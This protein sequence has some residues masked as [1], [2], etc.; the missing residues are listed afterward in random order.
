MAIKP[1]SIER[2]LQQRLPA[3]PPVKEMS[4]EQLH[5]I[6]YDFTGIRYEPVTA[7]RPQQL[8]GM[9]FLSVVGSG[10][11]FYGMRTGK[12]KMV[13]DWFVHRRKMG[14]ASKAIS[15]VPNPVIRPVW[16]DEAA[17]HQPSLRLRTIANDPMEFVDAA[18]DANVDMVVASW[19]SLQNI[20]AT[21]RYNPETKR[22]S[23]VEDLATIQLAAEF[24]DFAAID[25]IHGAK[26][27]ESLRYNICRHLIRQTRT[28]VG[29]TGTP[30]G[31]DPFALWAQAHLIDE[32]RCLGASYYFFK[33]AFGETKNSYFS[34]SG[35]QIVYDKKK[36]QLL[37]DKTQ[38]LAL[39]YTMFECGIEKV[40]PNRVRLKM[41]KEQHKH[42]SETANQLLELPDGSTRRVN[43]F[44]KLRMISS[45]YVPF[46]DDM[47]QKRTALLKGTPKLEW[48]EDIIE[49]H[50]DAC[51][52]IF[53][54]FEQSGHILSDLLKKHK[55]KHAWL[56]G[57]TKDKPGAVQKFKDGKVD[58]LIINNESGNAG[59]D[60][61]RANHQ[62]FF[63]S[64]TSCIIR[65]QAEARALGDRTGRGALFIDDLVCSRVEERILELHAEGLDML[66][67][68][69]F[70]SSDIL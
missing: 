60:L 22:T 56:Y 29:C 6:I 66:Q 26:D 20:F 55:I 44:I 65:Q 7:P 11:L 30:F 61:R 50:S 47:G 3:A 64:P 68:T 33:H 54:E 1:E 70:R 24:F 46:L 19:S 18:E 36:D 21:K 69:V 67:R 14:L 13:L 37:A 31:R 63:E 53:H 17:L 35:K 34:R 49:Q 23:M 38:P 27:H 9:A 43:A 40:K 48:L 52:V 10:L 2:Y 51:T 42:Y 59:I 39:S 8:A 58:W 57:G 16:I 12:T 32:G 28:R 15:I 45:G 25:E 62:I 5:R 4:P 41:T